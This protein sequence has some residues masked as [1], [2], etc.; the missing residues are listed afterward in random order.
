MDMK[1]SLSVLI[2]VSMLASMAAPAMAQEYKA[3]A[4]VSNDIMVLANE[5]TVETTGLNKTNFT[6]DQATVGAE[7]GTVSVTGDDATTA[8]LTL[9]VINEKDESVN[10]NFSVDS[11][12]KTV[13]LKKKLTKGTYKFRIKAE[14]DG[15]SKSGIS[16]V[17]TVEVTKAA[18]KQET[19]VSAVALQGNNAA[20]F[21]VDQDLSSVASSI[22]ES[23]LQ[24]ITI[25]DDEGSALKFGTAAA[26]TTS[27]TLTL[28]SGEFK[29]G[30]K[31]TFTGL[32]LVA[33]D[34][35]TLKA[36][37]ELSFTVP[38]ADTEVTLG[39]VTFENET[40][41]KIAVTG[42]TDAD[43]FK[44]A[45][46]TVKSNITV[47]GQGD[48]TID[49]AKTSFA[50][51][52]ITVTLNSGKTFTD[53]Q[54]YTFDFTSAVPAGYTWK[55]PSVQGTYNATPAPSVATNVT[56]EPATYSKD[57]KKV[58]L[59]T[60]T[61]SVDLT[62]GNALQ[63]KVTVEGVTTQPTVD[64]AQNTITL[65]FTNA[66]LTN[67]TTS[68]KKYTVKFDGDNGVE[69]GDPD[70]KFK[71]TTAEFTVEGTQAPDAVTATY[72]S[73]PIEVAPG[74]TVA[75]GT[76]VADAPTL[77][78]NATAKSYALKE[79]SDNLDVKPDGTIVTKKALG[80][81]SYTVTVNV[82]LNDA[83]STVV[84]APFTLTIN[85]K[86][87][88]PDQGGST[89]G[90]SSSSSNRH[91]RDDDDRHSNRY[92]GSS[93]VK[94][95]KTTSNVNKDGSVDTK[96]VVAEV[97]S[98][99]TSNNKNS[100]VLVENA[101]TVSASTLKE[102]AQAASTKGGTATLMADTVIKGKTE[103]RLY[104]DAAKAAN[105]KGEIKLGVSTSS[106][107]ALS[108]EKLFHKY[109]KNDIEVLTLSHN[110]GFGM[111]VRV[112]VKADLSGMNK[113]TLKFYSY[114]RAKNTYYQLTNVNYKIDS[115]GFV[116]FT[117]S[118][119]GDIIIT[120]APLTSK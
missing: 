47:K 115:H 116:H 53:K 51:N 97:K 99:I 17:V 86:S 7:V 87:T 92:N 70:A 69:F 31:Y 118:V 78:N 66:P 103:G 85:E 35:F 54:A 30:K 13:T 106:K 5:Y 73:K 89:G 25:T 60:N 38:A 58:V 74:A 95:D 16:E 80:K 104:I 15:K 119:G 83:S 23:E 45:F 46:D 100:S 76:K 111:S 36:Q 18:D 49:A 20:K 27:L 120:D 6:E 48:P 75:E 44:T 59:T 32:D 102:M 19:N 79:A 88:T 40:T 63:G 112:A 42:V 9:S 41:A 72:T 8:N 101:K 34:G 24:K 3:T 62:K 57:T 81:G 22:A 65:D 39:A 43:G 28:K 56:F 1:K 14:N 52:T 90:S 64:I 109:F 96:D 113:N 114:N 4:T 107:T 10:E 33:V 82:T 84:A 67:D 12:S 108:V 117:T 77:S 71:V 61:P 2:T 105:L 110:G 68:A 55:A 29:T 11:N 37:G 93:S 26:D 91:D 98:D 21:T 94:A 50:D